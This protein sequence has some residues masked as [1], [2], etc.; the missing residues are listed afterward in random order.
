M[1]DDERYHYWDAIGTI[2]Q[3]DGEEKDVDIYIGYEYANDDN[4]WFPI[5][6]HAYYI[7]KG[8]AIE[9]TLSEYESEIVS[10]ELYEA[11]KDNPNDEYC[12]DDN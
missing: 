5:I 2:V 4:G 10:E 11:M 3:E 7:D 8:V 9:Y 1:Y 12:A 6:D